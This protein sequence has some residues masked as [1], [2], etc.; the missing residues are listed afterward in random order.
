MVKSTRLPAPGDLE[1]LVVVHE[2]D[3]G[4]YLVHPLAAPTLASSGPLELALEEQRL[5]LGEHLAEEDADAVARFA[6]PATTTL[7]HVDV[8]VPRDGL[9]RKL[10]VRP[11]LSFPCVVV[12]H[13]PDRWVIALP[14]R[15]TF[16]VGAREDL[17]DAVRQEIRRLCLAQDLTPEEYAALLPRRR[18]ELR[19]LRVTID[20]AQ[21]TR[22]G[23][24]ARKQLVEAR[25]KK[26]AR[27]VLESVARRL[28]PDAGPP[29]PFVGRDAERRQLASL[30]GA[31]ERLSVVLVGAERIGKSALFEDWLRGGAE[32]YA[33]SGARLVA[34]MSGFGQWQERIRRTMEAAETR[35]AVLHFEN[36]GDLFSDRPDGHV[37]FP[38]VMRRFLEERRVR[39]VGELTP[40]AVA[41]AER[42]HTGFLAQFQSVRLEPLSVESTRSVLDAHVAHHRRHDA[43]TPTLSTEG[44]Q[45]V[46]DLVERYHPYGAYPGKAVRLLDDVRATTE[47]PP[48]G[49]GEAPPPLGPDDVHTTFSL[50]TGVPLFLLRDD[51]PLKEAEIRASLARR[52]V[53]QQEAVDR[54]ASLVTMVKARLQPS[55]K[56][57]ATLLFVG[58]TGVGKT[59]LAKSLAAFLFGSAERMVRF[60][61]SEYQDPF[62]AERLIRG[63]DRAEGLLTRRVRQQPFTVLLLDEIEKAHGAVFDLLLQVLGEGR[64]SDARGR[65]AFFHNAIV[66]L[67]SNLGAVHRS[68]TIGLETSP[69]SDQGYYEKEARR[70]FRPELVNRIDRIVPFR[71]LSPE[72]VR[73]VASLNVGR[74]RDRRGLTEL[75]VSLELGDD[76]VSTLARGGYS[77]HY[78]A[79]ALRRHLEDR[80]VA[81][82]ARLL[83]QA[84]PAARNARVVGVP[85]SGGLTFRMDS[86]GGPARKAETRGLATMSSRRR[87]VDHWFRLGPVEEI[88][89][90]LEFLVARLAARPKDKR[91]RKSRDVEPPAAVDLGPLQQEY[92]R[93]SDLYD[94]AAALR[95]ELHTFEELAL[96]AFLDNEDAQEVG[97]EAESAF[98]AFRGLLLKLLVAQR[99]GRDQIALL[100]QEVEGRPFDDWLVPLVGVAAERRWRLT[101]HVD[102][103]AL[104]G[105]GWPEMTARRFGPPRTPE[106][107]LEQLDV[108]KRPARALLLRAEG[109]WAGA[110]LSTECGLHR[111]RPAVGDPRHLLVTRLALR[112]RLEAA[113]WKHRSLLPVLPA[114]MDVVR[115]QPVTREHILDRGEVRLFGAKDRVVELRGARYWDT[116]DEVALRHLLICLEK[117]R[118]LP[119]DALVPD[120]ESLWTGPLDEPVPAGEEEA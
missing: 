119:K 17:E 60:D 93:L 83:G 41:L 9:P 4:E 58:P 71:P 7:L 63:T 118:G 104:R 98:E 45:T 114:Q 34:G 24:A 78:G 47:R 22:E 29:P 14:L 99:P 32:A 55:G 80:L 117:D 66:I 120:F 30:L 20:R 102:Q 116:I 53:G 50:K 113:D 5:F 62:A 74:I 21:A 108:A 2:L 72:E 100:M 13:G 112:S 23:R 106:A 1:T 39:V 97:P 56:P 89:E 6:F 40:E 57:L 12:P 88:G 61:M 8:H 107:V 38:R 59:E 90:H 11:P 82:L 91:R 69:V 52:V 18:T 48:T 19:P 25:R 76:A 65:T 95:T 27:E 96:Q 46:L 44:V 86:G 94:R 28:T 37:D 15:H 75:A 111:F 36:L 109:P 51:V 33:T 43:R 31:K 77:E 84:G 42:R 70:H 103:D 67:T 26:H 73:A 54:L 115:R 3:N 64:L 68:K 79:R 110:L 92:Y 105:D 81:P 87:Q 10:Q 101:V 35:D 49:S 16:H 85:A